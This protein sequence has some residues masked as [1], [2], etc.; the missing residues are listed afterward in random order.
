MVYLE[1]IST[2]HLLISIGILIL[3][4]VLVGAIADDE[5][6]S[7]PMSDTAKRMYS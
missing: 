4:C 1:V 3:M 7:P 6:K 5:Y 2:I